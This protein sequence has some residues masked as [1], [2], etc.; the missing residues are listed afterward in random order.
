MHKSIKLL[1]ASILSFTAATAVQAQQPQWVQISTSANGDRV[2]FDLGSQVKVFEAGYKQNTFRTLMLATSPER[3][4][5]RQKYHADCLKGTL[6]LRGI[7]LVNAQ[8]SLI[9]EVPLE[10]ADKDPTIPAKDSIAADVWRYACSQ[11]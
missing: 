10:R 9:R 11:F 5:F 2:F 4:S 6:S 3:R 8:G 1:A 7:D